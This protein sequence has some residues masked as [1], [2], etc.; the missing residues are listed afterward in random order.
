MTDTI[1]AQA[2][3]R[4]R[5]G[6]AVIRI[7]GPRAAQALAAFGA[8]PV[9]PRRAALRL[10]H[11]PTT[12]EAIDSALVLRFAAPASFTGED[13]VE[14]QLHGSLAV[15]RAVT[16]ALTRLPGL[17][18]AEP[19]EFT[20]RALMNGRLDLAQVE[21]LGDLI[22]A[23]TEAQRRQALR[24]MQ[25]AVGRLAAEWRAGLIAALA[26]IEASI[27]FGDEDIP[28]DLRPQVLP[29]LAAVRASMARELAGGAM[30][31]RLREGFEVALVGAPNAGK[32][33][34]LNALA[35]R[36]VAITSEVAGTTRD[37][38]EVRMDLRG[39]PVTLLDT[40]GLRA[41]GD[42]VERIGVERARDRAAAADL[43][44]VLVEG[45]GDA[46]A[47]GLELGPEDLVVRAKADLASGVRRHR[48]RRRPR[49]H[50]G[51]GRAARIGARGPRS[52]RI[53]FATVGAMS[54]N[55]A[56]GGLGK[57]HLVREVDALDGSW[58][59]PPTAP[60]SS[61]ASSTG[62]RVRPCAA[63]GPRPTGSSTPG[64]CRT[65][66]RRPTGSRSSRAKSPIWSCRTAGSPASFS[67]MAGRS[68][69]RRRHH[70][71]HV[72]ARPDPH[73]RDQDPGRPVGEAPSVGLGDHRGS[74]S[75]WAA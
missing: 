69:R 37:V 68:R 7:S 44:V 9:A 35:G 16:D 13:V 25:G 45:T 36:D 60:A 61:S 55:P 5:S 19:G 30:A 57:G 20:R 18:P 63:R 1:F 70:H 59:S 58:A 64:P 52:S 3:A 23:E 27:D 75:G 72:P 40:A 28:E 4:G 2:T 12:G 38:I 6:V 51:R 62:A 17:R 29:R 14:L 49:R 71:R 26:L 46:A 31:E 10:L 47:L 39:L 53:R 22:A 32:S 50:R 8:E 66:C 43:R 41:T 42:T 73:R 56:I 24:M 34:L 33:T 21:G 67:A 74:A 11:D 15:T 54:C 65:C 48:D